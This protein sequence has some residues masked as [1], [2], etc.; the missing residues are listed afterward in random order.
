MIF[1]LMVG[2]VAFCLLCIGEVRQALVD[3]V[4]R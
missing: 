4:R 3:A 1:W 2:T